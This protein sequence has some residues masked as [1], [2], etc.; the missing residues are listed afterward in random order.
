MHVGDVAEV[1]IEDIG[2]LQNKII[3]LE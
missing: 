3:S 1:N 2:I